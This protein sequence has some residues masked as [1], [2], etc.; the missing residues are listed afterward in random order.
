MKIIDAH[1]HLGECRVFG[2]DI[3][4]QEIIECMDKNEVHGVIVQPFPGCVDFRAT[5]DRIANFAAKHK[6]RIF[7]LCSLSPH[8]PRDEYQAEVERCVRQLG[9]VG[10]KLHTIGHAVSP[11]TEDG[12]TVFEVAAELG[13]P[14]M[15]H[16][17]IGIPFSQPSLCLPAIKRFPQIKV[18]LAH[19]GSGILSA[20]AHVTSSLYPN[21][22]LETSWCSSLDIAWMIRTLGSERVMLGSDL[23]SN[24]YSELSKYRSFGLDEDT[25][26]QVWEGTVRSVFGLS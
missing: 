12:M 8:R 11:L 16:T 3:S 22:Y 6:G 5:H 21:V 2:L 13:I 10:L 4:E 1:M 25:L 26:K 18:V 20:E 24:I 9:F 14:V 23:P 19:A 17:G 15:V 7:G